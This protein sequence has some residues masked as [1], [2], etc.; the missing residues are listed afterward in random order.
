MGTI[1][2]TIPDELKNTFEKHP[3]IN[4]GEVSREVIVKQLKKI[5]LIDFL[6]ETLDKSEFTEKDAVELGRK[7]KETR[8]K[9]LKDIRFA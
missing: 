5:E 8:F 3:E 4:W 6:D 2:I 7:I 1:I 9:Q